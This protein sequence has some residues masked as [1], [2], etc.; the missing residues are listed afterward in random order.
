MHA[1]TRHR[2]S[3]LAITLAVFLLSAPVLAGTAGLRIKCDRSATIYLDGKESG[4]CPKNLVV[5]PGHYTVLLQ[6]AVN[7]DT[8]YSYTQTVDLANDAVVSVDA[9]LTLYFTEAGQRK[10]QE[11]KAREEVASKKQEKK[12]FDY[13]IVKLRNDSGS[14]AR[15][16]FKNFYTGS[17]VGKIYSVSENDSVNV[18]TGTL[19]SSVCEYE[20]VYS[21]DYSRAST[22][23][24]FSSKKI[25]F[26]ICKV[27]E[28]IIT[29]NDVELIK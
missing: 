28:I 21:T 18:D 25:T 19:D 29:K 8:V 10:D 15:M 27:G 13:R 24:G 17:I 2:I 6:Q 16:F 26:D 11:R 4:Q 9:V 20:M 3:A 22:S 12:V 1:I 5:T 14:P 23:S 7:E